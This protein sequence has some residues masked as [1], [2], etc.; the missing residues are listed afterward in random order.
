LF[1]TTG[2][3]IGEGQAEVRA[4]AKAEAEACSSRPRGFADPVPNRTPSSK[5]TRRR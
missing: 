4:E 5:A 1:A 2:E 3:L